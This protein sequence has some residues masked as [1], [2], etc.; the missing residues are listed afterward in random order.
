M[1]DDSIPNPIDSEAPRHAD[2]L[3][4]VLCFLNTKE[5]QKSL[6]TDAGLRSVA[7]LGFPSSAHHY[8][9]AMSILKNAGKISSE[10]RPGMC[11]RISNVT[12]AATIQSMN[13]T[14]KCAAFNGAVQL[15]SAAWPFLK[16]WNSTDVERLQTVKK[17][18]PHI[19]ALRDN[20]RIFMPATSPSAPVPDIAFCRLLHEQAW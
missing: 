10:V 1:A 15:L 3:L 12:R 8:E 5:I 2:A 17:Y 14:E 16:I 20:C 9:Q 6:M 13:K 19:V 11:L 4:K 18:V 7:L